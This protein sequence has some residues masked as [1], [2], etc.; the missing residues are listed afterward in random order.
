MRLTSPAFAHGAFLP[1]SVGYE[2]ENKSPALIW[3]DLPAGIA[4]LALVCED[5][6]TADA[7]PWTHWLLWNIPPCETGLVSGLAAYERF[8][9]GM[10]QGYNDYLELGWGGP[11]PPTGVHSY[12]FNLFALDSLVYPEFR[13][14][15][16]FEAAIRYHIVDSA[17]LTGVYQ[18][19]NMLV[20]YQMARSGRLDWR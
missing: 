1:F 7:V 14:R 9:N 8:E 15:D 12:S 18:S 2:S 10:E 17:R 3:T 4:A 19:E 20:S 5:K 16:A 13:T 11:C 6:E